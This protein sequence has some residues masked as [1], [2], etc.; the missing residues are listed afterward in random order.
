MVSMHLLHM[1]RKA[2]LGACNQTLMFSQ[3]SLRVPPLINSFAVV[4]ALFKMLLHSEGV[5]RLINYRALDSTSLDSCARVT[6][7]KN[8]KKIGKFLYYLILGKLSELI[9]L[10]YLE[11]L[12]QAIV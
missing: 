3:D 11:F 10:I 5:W 8:E 12:N 7:M 6:P 1:G 2:H 9:S 4:R